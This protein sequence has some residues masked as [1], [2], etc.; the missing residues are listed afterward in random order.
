MKRPLGLSQ[1]VMRRVRFCA[2]RHLIEL[3]VAADETGVLQ[4]GET[5]GP[6]LDALLRFVEA[7]VPVEGP[8]HHS[9]ATTQQGIVR[10]Q[11]VQEGLGVARRRPGPYGQQVEADG[12]AD[13]HWHHA[14]RQNGGLQAL[15]LVGTERS[16]L[17]A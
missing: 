10:G 2:E 15:E 13:A 14:V 17:D 16:D 7:R 5:V 8:R 4:S 1:K 3:V 9:R 6:P 12:A 11:P